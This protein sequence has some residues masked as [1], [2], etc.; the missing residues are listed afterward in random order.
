M[1]ITF[2]P[3]VLKRRYYRYPLKSPADV[4]I[5]LIVNHAIS[6]RYTI[7]SETY[8][9]LVE[10][11]FT[12]ENN[13]TAT[14]QI[15]KQDLRVCS[16]KQYY[17]KQCGYCKHIGVL[18]YIEQNNIVLG[19]TDFAKNLRQDI[20]KIKPSP[21]YVC[22]IYDS[23]ND[24]I[25][26]IGNGEKKVKSVSLIE[27]EKHPSYISSSYE[28]VYLANPY[29]LTPEIS[30]YEYQHDI[31]QKMLSAKRA[32]CSMVMGAGKTLTSIGGIKH[33]DTQNV[34]IVCPKS[35][36]SQWI[37]EIKRVLNIDSLALTTQNIDDFVSKTNTIGVCTY[38]TYAR[39]HEKLKSRKYKVAILD[40][41]QFIRNDESKTWSAFKGLEAEYLWGLSGT[42]IENKLDDLFNIM[43]IIAPGLLGV[44]W[45]FDYK[46]K[47][48]KSIHQRKVL[49]LNETQNLDELKQ[50]ISK[51][52]FSYDKIG[53]SPPQ[54]FKY[55]VS[56]DKEAKKLHDGYIFEANK[57]ISKSLTQPITYGERMMI[58]AYLLKARQCCNTL[59]LIDGIQRKCPKVDAVLSLIDDICIKQDLKLVIFSEWTK[60]LDIVQG[61]LSKEIQYV[62]FDGSM[63]SKKRH[64]AKMRFMQDKDCKIFFSS[65]AGG[66][67]IDGLQT[68][69]H[70]VAH[71]ELPWN[72][73]K[74]DQ[75]NGR[76]NR[77]L[78][79]NGV[80]VHYII[81][82]DSIET[83]LEHTLKE[84]RKVRLETL[85]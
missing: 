3:G 1:Q 60:M 46:Y 34:L 4:E 51:N 21:S 24:K 68:V 52:V 30:L 16:C 55:Y 6:M 14:V 53:L 29:F 35:I 27:K 12:E 37:A 50:L 31:L 58:Q 17:E 75:R 15:F 40:E 72:P 78:Q 5:S 43:D 42:L 22:Q 70:N 64:E 74:L 25:I 81:A 44:K 47:K 45:K 73:A 38:Q 11:L 33:L 18:E 83:K 56:I 63:S 8:S 77:L 9:D 76:I 67:G 82:K 39:N 7:S 13:H 85:F 61:N 71:T 2:E 84:K 69:C 66:I 32:V 36:I 48:L 80:K 20:K 28:Q 49:Y 59:E 10:L 57:L 41:I 65:D 62:R 79:Q 19:L 54:F 26:G 23:L